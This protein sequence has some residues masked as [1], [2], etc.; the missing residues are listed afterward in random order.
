MQADRQQHGGK[1]AGII[2]AHGIHPAMA[3]LDVTQFARVGLLRRAHRVAGDAAAHVLEADLGR[4]QGLAALG[5]AG[6]HELAQN[7]VLDEREKLVV[8]LVLVMVAV[9]V[10]DQHA[11]QLALIRLPPRVGEQPTGVEFLD[12][13]PATAIGDEVHGVSPG[14]LCRRDG[15]SR[16]ARS[17]HGRCQDRTGGS[18]AGLTAWARPAV[19]KAAHFSLRAVGSTSAAARPTIGAGAP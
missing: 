13:H 12:R 4:H 7:L 18:S 8:A 16:E 1:Q 11:V 19:G 15:R 9:D 2:D 17:D 6:E 5:A 10:D 14:A 3:E